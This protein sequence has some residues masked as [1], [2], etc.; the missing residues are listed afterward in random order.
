M[1]NPIIPVL[2]ALLVTIMSGCASVP[3]A[4]VDEDTKA[5]TFNVQP[6]KANIYLFR[7]EVMGA[8]VGVPVML[9]GK[10]A[11]KTAS[12]SY[13]MWEVNPGDY[14]LMSVAEN[15]ST[16]RLR[17]QG[18]RSYYVWQEIKIGLFQPRTELHE[19]DEQRGRAGVTASTRI[20]PLP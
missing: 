4:S 5:K 11:G 1:K 14:E 20:L 9:N 3:M 15:T 17:A 18:G 7:D 6:G 19:V 10:M 12:K 2:M 16:V 8:A 13:F